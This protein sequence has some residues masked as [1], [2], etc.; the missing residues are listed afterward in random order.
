MMNG[1]SIFEIVQEM[2]RTLVNQIK[3]EITESKLNIRYSIYG[4]FRPIN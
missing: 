3:T 2:N 1:N 4:T